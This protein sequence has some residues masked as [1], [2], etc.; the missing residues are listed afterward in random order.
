M[1]EINRP[2]CM[3]RIPTVLTAEE[4]ARLLQGMDGTI[5]LVARLLHGTGMVR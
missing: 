1:E 4:V 5:Q 3:P 2:G